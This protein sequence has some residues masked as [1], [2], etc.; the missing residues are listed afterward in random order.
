M[1]ESEKLLL[2]E[3][4]RTAHLPVEPNSGHDDI[5]ASDS[6]MSQF[7]SGNIYIEEKI[8]ATNLGI[9]LPGEYP[10]VRN[11]SH[12]LRKGYDKRKTPAQIQYQRVWTWLY[13][14]MEKFTL[15][16]REL[17][18]TAS[19]YGEWLYARHVVSYDQLP[20]LFIAY[21]I[22]DSNN[23][24][25]LP[26]EIARK[27]LSNAGFDIAPLISVGSYT[28]QDLIDIRDGESAFSTISPREG[29]Y[30]KSEDGCHRYKMVSPWF[31]SDDNWNKKE[32]VKNIV[33]RR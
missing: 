2:P 12:I 26:P 7:L 11:R 30:L 14:N 10:V 13:E 8:D 6:D 28:V 33:K 3:F 19:V 22:Y 4:P 20:N 32:L 1:Y 31:Q 21:D 27:Y 15:L 5:I 18:F 17:G 16:N 24:K 23:R 29:I 9:A 25:F